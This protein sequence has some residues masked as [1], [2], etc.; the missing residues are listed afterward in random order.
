[1]TRQ[2]VSIDV[3]ESAQIDRLCKALVSAMWHAGD[4]A[5]AANGVHPITVR[6]ALRT[7]LAPPRPDEPQ[8]LGAVV[9]DEQGARWIRVGAQTLDEAPRAW[10]RHGNVGALFAWVTYADIA[11][12]KV[13]SEG[14]Q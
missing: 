4:T 8:G 2:V 11:V 12:T 14:V 13:L 10:A 1:M 3:D 6:K 7:L 9:E 5:S